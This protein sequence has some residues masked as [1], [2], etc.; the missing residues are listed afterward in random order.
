LLSSKLKLRDKDVIAGKGLVATELIE[1][2]E[3]LWEADAGSP[4]TIRLTL[5]QTKQLPWPD[6]DLYRQCG[7]DYFVGIEYC[8]NHSCDPNCT[9]DGLRM[10]ALRRIHPEEEATYDYGFSEIGPW[11]LTCQCG[12]SL[13]RGVVSNNDFLLPWL[14]RRY[15]HRRQIPPYVQRAIDASGWL[16]RATHMFRSTT[17]AIKAKFRKSGLLPWQGP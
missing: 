8:W 14:Q 12:S 5:A 7:D 6:K 10:Y 4:L 11:R 16:D 9:C 17:W 3:L 13:C 1:P 15:R 2:G